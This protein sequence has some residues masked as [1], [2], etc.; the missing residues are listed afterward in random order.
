VETEIQSYVKKKGA[1]RDA[2]KRGIETQ[3]EEEEDGDKQREK[4]M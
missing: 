2:I 1:N 3:E 4:E